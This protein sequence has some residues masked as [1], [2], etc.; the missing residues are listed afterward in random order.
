MYVQ[1]MMTSCS[2]VIHLLADL[3]LNKGA[4]IYVCGGT[5]MGQDIL[6]TFALLLG[7][8]LENGGIDAPE[9]QNEEFRHLVS[10][11]GDFEAFNTSS[12]AIYDGRYMNAYK[13][14][15]DHDFL[16]KAASFKQKGLDLIHEMEGNG[17][18][19]Q[20]LWS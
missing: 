4:Y 11:D 2:E 6:Q 7:D 10:E 8:F 1:H 20:E 18:Y 19:V 13:G 5:R 3:V 15:G 12:C 9:E 17:R 16:D 14:S